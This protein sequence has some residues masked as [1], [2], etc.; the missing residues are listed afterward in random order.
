[1]DH[2]SRRLFLRLGLLAGAGAAGFFAFRSWHKPSTKSTLVVGAL[3]SK[4]PKSHYI[5]LIEPSFGQVNRIPVRFAG[6]GFARNPLQPNLMIMFPH[7]QS[8][9][10][11]EFDLSS[12]AVTR[13]FSS[14]PLHHFYG[15]GTFS[16]DGKVLFSTE[17][18]YE[19]EHGKITMRDARSLE[20]IG[21]F[22]SFG[23][24]P[25]EMIFLPDGHTVAIANGGL[26]TDPRV[27]KGEVALGPVQS[28]LVFVDIATRAL[29]K[30]IEI[31]N[32]MLSFRHL[33]LL[34]GDEVAVAIQDKGF[35]SGPG[36]LLYKSVD[37]EKVAAFEFPNDLRAKAKHHSLSV[38]TIDNEVVVLTS[39]N[40]NLVTLWDAESG[41]MLAEQT[42][43]RASGVAVTGADEITVTSHTGSA[44]ILE[45][46]S[47]KILREIPPIEPELNW[48]SHLYSVF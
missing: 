27:D 3:R 34:P 23:V 19:G 39:P 30:K 25:H 28:S 18:D 37:Q 24:D 4:D 8:P 2:I 1:M 11:C 48:G 31:D 20:L 10:A 35:G 16:S 44:F 32:T 7:E 15:H 33:S 36:S 40:G 38:A 46:R 6:H 43:P 5:G 17:N 26:K 9:E 41:R 13:Y 47:L 45:A 14:S 12:K 29:V 21:E 42:V 22:P